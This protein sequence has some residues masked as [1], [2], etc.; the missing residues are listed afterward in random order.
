MDGCSASIRFW[1]PTSVY[2]HLRGGIGGE[3]YKDSLAF[4]G[5]YY[6][7]LTGWKMSA[8]HELHDERPG[9]WL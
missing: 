5:N 7:P 9:I 2:S 1:M 4:S 8:A 3:V 6:F